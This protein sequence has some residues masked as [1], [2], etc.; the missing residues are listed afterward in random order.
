MG[1]KS[2]KRRLDWIAGSTSLRALNRIAIILLSLGGAV[3]VISLLVAISAQNPSTVSAALVWAIAS[4]IVLGMGAQVGI[5][6]L[7]ANAV[8]GAIARAN[9]DAGPRE[10]SRGKP[11][12]DVDR[13]GQQTPGTG[14]AKPGQGLVE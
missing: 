3:C 1:K 7:A 2:V 6:A 10:W 9:I 14:N 8:V 4:G 12:G 11:K 13:S 5:L